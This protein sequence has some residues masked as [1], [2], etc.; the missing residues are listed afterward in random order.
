LISA[1]LKKGRGRPLLQDPGN[2][3][4]ILT[5]NAIISTPRLEIGGRHCPEDRLLD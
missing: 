2:A 4:G 5:P 3:M 1:L